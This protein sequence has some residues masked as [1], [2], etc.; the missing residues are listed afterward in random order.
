MINIILAK[1]GLSIDGLR[2]DTV[3]NVQKSFWPGYN[4]AAGVYCMGEIFDGDVDYTC[5]YQEVIDGVLDL[6]YVS[7]ISVLFKI[8]KHFS[9]TP[10]FMQARNN[11][12]MGGNDPYNREATWLSGYNTSSALYKLIAQTDSIRSYAITK[13]SR[14]ITSKNC[15]IYQDEKTPPCTRETTA[16]NY[17]LIQPWQQ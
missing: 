8:E 17:N 11:T 7:T 5:P 1:Y 13:H 10:L 3:R 14:Y 16:E 6:R 4:K 9:L 12:T 2:L 15:P